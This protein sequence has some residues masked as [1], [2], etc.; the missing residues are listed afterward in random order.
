[1]LSLLLTTLLPALLPVGIDALKAGVNRI[2]DNAGAA[3]SNFQERMSFEEFQLK[4]LQALA[5]MDKPQGQISM[6][7]ADLRASARYIAVFLILGVWASITAFNLPL[8]TQEY[9]LLAALAQSAF[10]FL[11]GDRIYMGLKKGG[12]A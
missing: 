9:E 6:W 7:V 10:F 11:F 1:M 12:T 2:T 3:P 4:K 8:D 5:E